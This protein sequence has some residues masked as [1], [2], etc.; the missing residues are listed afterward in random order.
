MKYVAAMMR[1]MRRADAYC[2][3]YCS[4]VVGRMRGIDDVVE[5]SPGRRH[6]SH[7]GSCPQAL[8]RT[9]D[10]Q[11]LSGITLNLKSTPSLPGELIMEKGRNTY[12]HKITPLAKDIRIDNSQLPHNPTASESENLH[13]LG[14]TIIGPKKVHEKVHPSFRINDPW[15]TP[16]RP[17]TLSLTNPLCIFSRPNPTHGIPN[18]P[19][20]KR[21]PYGVE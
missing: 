19:S 18:P 5:S 1:C 12:T 20:P 8:S 4:E 3:L 17:P 9:V 7:P 21:P 10:T 13:F 6:Q 11:A 2:G 15:P 16:K 14:F